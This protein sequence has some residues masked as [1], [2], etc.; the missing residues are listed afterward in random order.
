MG[1]PNGFAQWHWA[2]PLG[3]LPPSQAK[4]SQA[5]R[6]LGIPHG[7]GPPNYIPNKSLREGGEIPLWKRGPGVDFGFP[8]LICGPPTC[9]AE[10]ISGSR[11]KKKTVGGN[12]SWPARGLA[13]AC[14]GWVCSMGL[15]NAIGQTHWANPLGKP[16]SAL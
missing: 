3:T 6:T 13:W 2:N 12:G 8:N 5:G 1:L 7:F 11:Y 4:P 16:L 14:P 9:E 10:I 15:P